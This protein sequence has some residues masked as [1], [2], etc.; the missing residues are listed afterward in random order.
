MNEELSVPQVIDLDAMLQPVS[1]ESPSGE[2]LRYS[3]LYDEIVE[4]R[5]SDD[6]LS[7][8]EWQT[9]LKVADYRKVVELAVPALTAKA[10]DL[11]VAAWLSESLIK[12]YGFAGL[13]DSLKLVSGLQDQFW[14]TLHPVID[15]GDMEGRANAISWLDVQGATAIKTCPITGGAGYSYNDWLTARS[16]ETPANFDSLDPEKQQEFNNQKAQAE[17]DGRVTGD[18]WKI[19]LEKTKRAQA[20]S[21][22]YTI[23]ECWEAFAELNRVIEEKYDRNQMPGLSALKRALEDVHGQVKKILERKRLEEPDEND[24]S[25]EWTSSDSD[26]SETSDTGEASSMTGAVKSRS[27]ALRRLSEIAVFFQ[28][29]EP[30]SPVAYLVNR[31]VKWGNMPLDSWLQEVIKD[32]ATL[33]QINEMLGIGGSTGSGDYYSTPTEEP[34]DS[35]SSSSDEW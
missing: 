4:A 18:L 27:D 10:K 35:G 25:D 29:T 3:G 28:R 21:I 8:G 26:H 16:L 2:S 12:N 9:E 14:D 11:Q 6:N 20:E 22:N 34:S 31:A 33:E 15:E 17:T 32:S 7:Q 5:R 30:H 19:A 24:A 1:E 23:E 13:R